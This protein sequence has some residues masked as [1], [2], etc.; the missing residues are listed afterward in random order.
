MSD[1]SFVERP[2]L[3]PG[4]P[5][6]MLLECKPLLTPD[7]IVAKIEEATRP[8]PAQTVSWIPIALGAVLLM[9]MLR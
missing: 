9:W 6:F 8:E 5:P 2:P 1:C 4:L 7:E 3:L